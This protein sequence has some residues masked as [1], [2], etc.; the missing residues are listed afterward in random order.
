MSSKNSLFMRIV[1]IIAESNKLD[2]LVLLI[3]VLIPVVATV[4]LIIILG[5][6]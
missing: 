4:W 1:E 3:L 6:Q 2:L 5:I